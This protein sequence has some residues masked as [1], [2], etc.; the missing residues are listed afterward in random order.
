MAV[1]SRSSSDLQFP[2]RHFRATFRHL[3]LTPNAS[4]K[5]QLT[6]LG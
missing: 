2:S 6:D 5:S 1:P 4:D 3:S